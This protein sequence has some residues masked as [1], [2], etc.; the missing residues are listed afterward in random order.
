MKLEAIILLTAMGPP[1]GGRSNITARCV[2]HFNLIAY[3]DLDRETIQLIFNSI[4]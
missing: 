1:G 3:P 2:R 4:S